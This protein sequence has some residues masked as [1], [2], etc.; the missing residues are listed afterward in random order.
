M[1]DKGERGGGGTERKDKKDSER[2]KE[3]AGAIE[4]KRE[5]ERARERGAWRAAQYFLNSAS[6][7]GLIS[8]FLLPTSVQLVLRTV[9]PDS[10]WG[11]GGDRDTVQVQDAEYGASR[12][13]KSLS[14][15]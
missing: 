13:P 8:T 11:G 1:E 15:F 7:G 2:E 14:G 6:S 3:R 12:L 10:I 5:K 4:R 9:P